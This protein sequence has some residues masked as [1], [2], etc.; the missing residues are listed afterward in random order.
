MKT[1]TSQPS[2]AVLIQLADYFD[3]SLDYLFDRT[4]YKAG[5]RLLENKL[6]GE[7]AAMVLDD[8]FALPP[9]DKELVIHMV[10]AL[11]AHRK[12][13]KLLKNKKA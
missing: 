7:K 6:Q 1:G 11:T 12:Y 13:Q 4:A 8:L 10:E 5:T 2:Y 9:Q 3:V